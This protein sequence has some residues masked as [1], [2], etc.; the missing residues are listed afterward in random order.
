MRGDFFNFQ[1]VMPLIQLLRYRWTFF[2][3]HNKICNM[4][5]WSLTRPNFLNIASASP[6][7]R[8]AAGFSAWSS[9]RLNDASLTPSISITLLLHYYKY[10]FGLYR[11][12]LILLCIPNYNANLLFFVISI[13][14]SDYNIEYSFLILNTIG[15]MNQQPESACINLCIAHCS[16][17]WK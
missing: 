17:C 12:I 2:T 11:N 10:F 5:P 6:P 7:S 16:W 14:K 1:F 4:P 9:Y 13:N 3:R 15:W 8:F